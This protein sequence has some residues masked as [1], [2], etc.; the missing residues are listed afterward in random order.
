[1]SGSA[2]AGA[3][4]LAGVRVVE[5]A[6]IGPAP[7]AAMVLA[8]L[9]ADVVRVESPA[10]DRA[11]RSRDQLLR[12]RRVVTADL[13]RSG[14]RHLLLRLV[15]HAD[16]LLE[17]FRPGVAERLG[18]GPDECLERNPGLVYARMTGWGQDGPR[19]DAAGHDINFLAV[20]GALHAIGRRGER[21]VPPLNLVADFG[22]GSMLVVVGILAALV[23]RR[24]SGCGQVVDAA[25][26]DGTALLLQ[27][28]WSMRGSGRWS[29]ERDA[30]VLDGAAPY[31]DTYE[32]ADGR[33][34]AVGAVEEKFYDR[35]A[36]ALGM[37]PGDLPDRADAAQWPALRRRFA[38][39]IRRQPRDHWAKVFE[40]VDAC[41]TPV[42]T[43]AEAAHDP[44][45]AARGGLVDSAG[46]TQAAPAPR[47]SRTA[48]GVPAPPPSTATAAE[49]VLAQWAADRDEKKTRS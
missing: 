15:R 47:F 28:V 19:R 42:L 9:G 41:V 27:M 37:T 14:D 2:A 35:F 11:F 22:G 10:V 17:G 39:A 32:C 23:E 6:G 33:W 1:M 49:E 21:P 7:H 12:G 46:V 8:D 20:T 34:I 16:V 31:Y 29:D 30:N 38:E 44:Q 13:K 18:V 24:R 5:L 36:T 48:T 4:P 25:M 3:G 43:F 45:I 26:L 40:T